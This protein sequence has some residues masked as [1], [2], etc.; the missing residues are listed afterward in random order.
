MVLGALAFRAE[1]WIEPSDLDDD[2]WPV[3]V[4]KHIVQ[5]IPDLARGLNLR[6]EG[7][8]GETRMGA[9]GIF[10]TSFAS[11]AP[12]YTAIGKDLPDEFPRIQFLAPIGPHGAQRAGVEK[13]LKAV[14]Q[15]LS[16]SWAVDLPL[17]AGSEISGYPLAKGTV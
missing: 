8:P 9:G 10:L 16:R 1:A 13:R 5:H 14:H 11:G 6:E 3:A 7:A 4:S 2:A 17:P 12:R 15:L